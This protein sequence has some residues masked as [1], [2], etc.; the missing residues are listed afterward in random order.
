MGWGREK[1]DWQRENT[2]LKLTAAKGECRPSGDKASHFLRAAGHV[3]FLREIPQILKSNNQFRFLYTLTGQA[4]MQLF[5]P[6][7]FVSS[8]LNLFSGGLFF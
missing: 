3:E 2:H 4:K 7:Q 5:R 1:A 6:P 8:D